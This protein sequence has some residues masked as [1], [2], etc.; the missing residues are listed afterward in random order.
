MDSTT[1]VNVCV[2]EYIQQLTP[3]QVKALNIAKSHLGTSF[4]IFKS[5]GYIEWKK[6]NKK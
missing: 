4:N 5:N 6:T 2:E 3:L 1:N